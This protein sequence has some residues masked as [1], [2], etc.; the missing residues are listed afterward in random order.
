MKC[1]KSL[2][3]AFQV[4]STFENLVGEDTPNPSTVL[5]RGAFGVRMFTIEHKNLHV[6]ITISVIS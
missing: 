4:C 1:S 2:E 3:M 6:C 5:E